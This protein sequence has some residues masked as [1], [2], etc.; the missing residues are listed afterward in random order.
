MQIGEIINLFEGLCFSKVLEASVKEYGF[1]LVTTG[2]QYNN[3]VKGFVDHVNTDEYYGEHLV[4]FKIS[5]WSATSGTGN[6][7]VY[8]FYDSLFFDEEGESKRKAALQLREETRKKKLKAAT[9]D[10]QPGPVF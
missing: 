7:L 2:E 3:L 5:D 10:E 4:D 9:D 6:R 8:H 1:D